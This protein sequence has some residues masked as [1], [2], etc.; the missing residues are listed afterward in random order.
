M[1]ESD[2][3]KKRLKDEYAELSERI[4]RL[5]R[6]IIGHIVF[7]GT[8]D[9]SV[10]LKQLELLNAQGHAMKLYQFILAERARFAGIEL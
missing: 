7:D 3:W 5:D 10:R 4:S 1:A 8:D 2:D 6:E 9:E